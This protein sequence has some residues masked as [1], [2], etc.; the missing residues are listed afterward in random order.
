LRVP[1]LDHVCGKIFHKFI[2]LVKKI[3]EVGDLGDEVSKKDGVED[4]PGS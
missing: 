1:I 2:T 3:I 4:P